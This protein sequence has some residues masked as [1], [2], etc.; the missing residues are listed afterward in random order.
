MYATMKNTTKKVCYRFK[1]LF[2]EKEELAR[3]AAG[4]VNK[5][6]FVVLAGI[7]WG[8]LKQRPQQMANSLSKYEDVAIL[9][10]VQG[11][12]QDSFAVS[13]QIKERLFLFSSRFMHLLD[14]VLRLAKSVTAILQ[15]ITNYQMLS[16]FHSDKLIYEYMDEL[17]LF[18]KDEINQYRPIHE[19]IVRKA[20][21]V[22]TTATTLYNDTIIFNRNSILLPNAVDYTFFHEN[23]NQEVPA[24]LRD[25]IA[26]FDCVIGYYGALASWFDYEL[27]KEVA[28]IHPRWLCLLAGKQLGANMKDSG[29]EALPNVQYLGEYPYQKLPFFISSCDI[30]TIPFVIN[31]ITKSTSPVKLFEYMASQRPILSADLNE[32]RKYKSVFIYNNAEEFANKVEILLNFKDDPEYLKLL[33]REASENTWDSRA[34]EVIRKL[35][36]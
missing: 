32:C 19:N 7:H 30:L 9:Y 23:R 14:N 24:K 12:W 17:E 3:V 25:I 13:K 15:T 18:V 20:N 28:Q 4:I 35:N 10:I 8:F 21:L 34:A 11:S 27:V 36:L 22:I 31:A 1:A 2:T 16:Q 5:H 33:D 6:V 29:I 26:P